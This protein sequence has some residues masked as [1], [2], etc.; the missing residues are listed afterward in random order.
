MKDLVEYLIKGI[1]G[2]E[3]FEAE[4]SDDNGR[5]LYTIKTDP[6]NIGL[7]IGKGGKTIKAIRN[8]VKI[9]ATLEKTAVSVNIS[10]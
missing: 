9:R 5:T 4:E 1:L 8:I 7:L 10:E 2:K 3:K 6:K